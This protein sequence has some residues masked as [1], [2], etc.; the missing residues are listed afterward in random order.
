MDKPFVLPP[1]PPRPSY[2]WLEAQFLQWQRQVKQK[3]I[4]ASGGNRIILAFIDWALGR[5]VRS[6]RKF[7]LLFKIWYFLGHL[8]V[9]SMR[10]ERETALSVI[11]RR[12]FERD[13]TPLTQYHGT[14]VITNFLTA[15]GLLWL[16]LI[17]F[18]SIV[19]VAYI[20]ITYQHNKYTNVLVKHAYPDRS[21]P[22]VF[23]IHGD[24]ILPNGEK[25]EL[26]AE[27]GPSFLFQD[28]IPENVFNQI[29]ENSLC[30]FD[31]YGTLLRWPLAFRYFSKDSL[32]AL[33]PWIVGARCKTP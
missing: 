22:H 17:S 28:Y 4:V 9:R 21:Y 7:P 19:E 32:W 14:Y 29:T 18:T 26:F 11:T 23:A 31:A 24:E 2:H 30:D 13:P 3:R 25:K 10:K 12:T 1:L 8:V 33:N 15:V 5:F 6:G 27:I 16:F 20:G